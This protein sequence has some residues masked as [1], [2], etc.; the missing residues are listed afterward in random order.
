MNHPEQHGV[1]V[2]RHGIGGQG[3][4]GG[5]RGRNRSLIDPR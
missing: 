3:L 1:D 5:E 4:L 2:D